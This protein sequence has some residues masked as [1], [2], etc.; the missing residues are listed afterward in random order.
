MVSFRQLC[1][2]RAKAE[3][4]SV[5]RGARLLEEEWQDGLCQLP[6][7]ELEGDRQ[8]KPTLMAMNWIILYLSAQCQKW[9]N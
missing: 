6:M 3:G 1:Y 2:T 8:Q 4:Q 7:R 9:L 5:S